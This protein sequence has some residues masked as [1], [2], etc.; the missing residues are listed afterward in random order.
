MPDVLPV[1]RGHRQWTICV[2]E[3]D[4]YTFHVVSP[5]N[6]VCH[7]GD[8]PS[9]DACFE[10]AIEWIDETIKRYYPPHPLGRYRPRTHMWPTVGQP[11]GALFPREYSRKADLEVEGVDEVLIPSPVQ[12]MAH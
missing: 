2:Y 10:K 3:A 1:Q 8:A 5:Y 12:L 9:E 11:G 4:P 6:V 7:E